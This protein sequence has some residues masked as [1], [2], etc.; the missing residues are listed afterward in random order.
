MNSDNLKTE[1]IFEHLE[2][3]KQKNTYKDKLGKRMKITK[4]NRF[5]CA[6]RLSKK[7]EFQSWSINFISLSTIISG[8]YLLAFS[9]K[10]TVSGV[11]FVG[12]F[13]IGISVVAILLSRQ[14]AVQ[15]MSK[16]STDAHRCGREVSQL[17]RQMEAGAVEPELASEKYER[18]IS[19]YEDNHDPCDFMTTLNFYKTEMK[20]E[21]EEYGASWWN[22]NLVSFFSATSPIIY[23]A[24][25]VCLIVAICLFTPMINSYFQDIDSL[26]IIK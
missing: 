12:V 5:N 11:Q 4:S 9:S 15:E 8:T 13:S 19:N 24:L 21:R 23:T 3:D 26:S 18:I 14:G 16:R 25:G 17:Y 20:D 2:E 1:N 10:L 7:A 6:K 22:G